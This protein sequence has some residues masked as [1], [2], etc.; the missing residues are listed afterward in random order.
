MF[1]NTNKKFTLGW[2]E[3]LQEK[4]NETDVPFP[5]FSPS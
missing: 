1:K 5:I 2:N 4:Q 3:N